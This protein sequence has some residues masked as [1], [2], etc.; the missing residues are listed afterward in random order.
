[1]AVFIRNPLLQGDLGRGLDRERGGEVRSDPRS[2]PFLGPRPRASG[3]ENHRL[4]VLYVFWPPDPVRGRDLYWSV[5]EVRWFE[6][7]DLLPR[8]PGV[9]PPPWFFYLHSRGSRPEPPPPPL[10]YGRVSLVPSSLVGVGPV[11]LSGRTLCPDTPESN[12]F[13]YLSTTPDPGSRVYTRN[14]TSSGVGWGLLKGSENRDNP[15]PNL[16]VAN[17]RT[18][19]STPCTPHL[20]SLVHPSL[21]PKV[22]T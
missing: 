3:E 10:S 20:L 21:S 6:G 9:A 1:M 8:R 5:R 12:R 16:G 19:R 15:F 18:N 4:V 7:V 11:V 17:P 14:S 13:D 22:R 2:P